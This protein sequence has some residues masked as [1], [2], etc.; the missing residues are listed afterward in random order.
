VMLG[1]GSW[2]KR[3]PLTLTADLLA[4]TAAALHRQRLQAVLAQLAIP[5]DAEAQTSQPS[6]AQMAAPARISRICAT[7][8]RSIGSR[9]LL[10]AVPSNVRQIG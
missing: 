6:Q 2:S 1:S 5:Q 7:R 4:V 9:G 8:T 3:T 10:D